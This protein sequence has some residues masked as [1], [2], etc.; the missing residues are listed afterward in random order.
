MPLD[1]ERLPFRPETPKDGTKWFD[2]DRH[3][4]M[5]AAML[6]ALRSHVGDD[7]YR[8]SGKNSSVH[9]APEMKRTISAL[10]RKCSESCDYETTVDFVT[11]GAMRE[12]E[13]RMISRSKQ[14]VLKG[15]L[16]AHSTVAHEHMCPTSEVF[17]CLTSRKFE[18]VSTAE[19]LKLLTVRALVSGPRTKAA[20]RP[21]DWS[22][23]TDVDKLDSKYANRIPSANE[24]KELV[25]KEVPWQYY[26]LLRYHKVGLL[27][28]LIAVTGRA[29]TLVREYKA[30]I[31]LHRPM[32]P[33]VMV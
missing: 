32:E 17:R 26:P 16:A 10:V 8:L 18:S 2:R 25:G 28:D 6:D 20:Q 7:W 12:I 30:F 23:W 5:Y 33:G 19:V 22:G 24:M 21:V 9:L 3:I 15:D 14:R 29:D 4:Q 27:D 31:G 1:I 13:K 11:T